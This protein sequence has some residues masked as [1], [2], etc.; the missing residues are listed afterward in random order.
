MKF[1]ILCIGKIKKG[2]I[3]SGIEDYGKRF[4]LE[5]IELKDSNKE[6]ESLD[7]LK[8][9]R[10]NAFVVVLSEEGTKFNS[11]SFAKLIKEKANSVGTIFFIIGGPD[12]LSDCVKKKANL[13]LS[14]SQMT[15]THEMARLF[16][17]EQIYRA[18]SINKGMKYHRD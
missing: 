11:N 9:I 3:L 5:I 1:K 14:L 2:W 7:L 12:G 4:P 17:V 10:D 6:K 15:F 8:K 18:I 16:L 13:L